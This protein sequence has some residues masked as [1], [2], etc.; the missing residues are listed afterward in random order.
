MEQEQN[1]NGYVLMKRESVTQLLKKCYRANYMILVLEYVC[2]LKQVYLMLSAVEVCELLGIKPEQLTDCRKRKW[3]K[4]TAQVNGHYLYK[5]YD[6]AVLAER[7]K[8]RKLL[9]TLSKIPN[10]PLSGE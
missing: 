7:L 4:A 5:A 1:N 8:R 2:T 3:V 10:M 6:V 9:R